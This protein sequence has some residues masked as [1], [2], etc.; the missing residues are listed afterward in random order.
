[1]KSNYEL[2]HVSLSV[3]PHAAIRSVLLRMRNVLDK[4]L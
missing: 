4:N 3:R 1:V 2:R